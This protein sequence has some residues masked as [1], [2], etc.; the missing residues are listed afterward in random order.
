MYLSKIKSVKSIHIVTRPKL[1]TGTPEYLYY[2]KMAGSIES[3]R[4]THANTDQH[5]PPLRPIVCCQ[6]METLFVVS[7]H[8]HSPTSACPPQLLADSFWTMYFPYCCCTSCIFFYMTS[9]D[10]EKTKKSVNRTAVNLCVCLSVL[11]LFF[12]GLNGSRGRSTRV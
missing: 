3:R 9:A 6:S 10:I 4:D 5:H 8:L 7:L 2:F 1:D 11:L 12:R